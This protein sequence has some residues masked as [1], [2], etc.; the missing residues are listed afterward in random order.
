M[1]QERRGRKGGRKRGR[2]AHRMSLSV[3]SLNV[4]RRSA[5]AFHASDI[6]AARCSTRH[7]NEAQPE[8]PP[9]SSDAGWLGGRGP[10]KDVEKGRGGWEGRASG[11]WGL[12][13]MQCRA[14]SGQRE[15]AQV[16]PRL[17]APFSGLKR[18]MRRRV[19]ACVLTAQGV[20]HSPS[21]VR[22]CP[23]RHGGVW[24]PSRTGPSALW[25]VVERRRASVPS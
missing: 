1:G 24:H 7:A 14:N 20:T 3:S 10:S 8:H 12:H 21:R 19:C 2:G 18:Y 6:A 13:A 17:S 11:L 4:L 25:T 9:R 23:L 16:R 15:Q 5:S 22:S